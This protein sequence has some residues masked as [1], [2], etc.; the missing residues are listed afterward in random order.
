MDDADEVTAL[1]PGAHRVIRRLN[2]GESAFSGALVSDGERQRVSTDAGSIDD[3]LW[4]F[5]AAEHVAGVRDLVRAEEG[6]EVLLPWCTQPLDVVLARRE[7]S[8]RPLAAGE[9]VTLVGSLLRGIIEVGGAE[10]LGRWWLDDEKRPLFVIGEG[11]PCTDASVEII[12][13]IRRECSDRA[14]ERV[15]GRIA[16]A[17]SDHRV[18]VRA[19]DDWEREL[20]EH[21]APRA[22]EVDVYTPE[23]VREIPAHR[24][25]LPQDLE[26]IRDS[27]PLRERLDVLRA[28]LAERVTPL[29]VRA[30]RARSRGS[31]RRTSD[32]AVRPPRRRMLV[33]GA[34]AA[35]VVLIGGL[36]WPTGGDDSTA[37]TIADLEQLQDDTDPAS[38]PAMAPASA[39][40]TASATASAAAHAARAPS[41]PETGPDGEE[42]DSDDVPATGSIEGS[43]AELLAS[44][45]V[46]RAEQD[47]ECESAV[48]AGAGERILERLA[49]D[50]AQRELSLI[51]DYGDIAVLR[52]SGTRARGEQMLVIARQSDRWLARD[53]YDVVDQ[54]SVQG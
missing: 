12:G 45:D 27:R 13:R 24:A 41:Q 26:R 8:S 7:R 31:G 52:L 11:M 2:N 15:L 25:R 10:V 28:A 6:Q 51:E 3:A 22:I 49:V 9:I 37:K 19:L 44:I 16:D 34:A 4:R 1:V 32:N 21:A 42:S 5:A 46:C 53:V 35:G 54:P 47:T 33:V 23:L 39:P 43:A 30:L 29:R 36:L 38:A 20:T 50:S 40:A 14:L 48:V 18:V 17:G